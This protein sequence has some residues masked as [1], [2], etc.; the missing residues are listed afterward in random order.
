MCKNPT[1]TCLHTTSDTHH[2]TRRMHRQA[3]KCAVPG[4]FVFLCMLTAGALPH[5]D[6][7][8]CGVMWLTAGGVPVLDMLM[9]LTCGGNDRGFMVNDSF[10][11][12]NF[13]LCAF[14][15][16]GPPAICACALL[17]NQHPKYPRRRLK[18]GEG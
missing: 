10:S 12:E 13:C 5:P 2:T 9:I 6:P 16:F 15:L 11:L 3:L 18:G 4:F 17:F 14:P 7:P 1:S 8:M